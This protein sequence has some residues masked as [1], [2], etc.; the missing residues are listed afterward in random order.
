MRCLETLRERWV[1]RLLGL[2]R[3]MRKRTHWLPLDRLFL[4]LISGAGHNLARK[5]PSLGWISIRPPKSVTVSH[6][7]SHEVVVVGSVAG[8][9]GSWGVDLVA[10]AGGL[11]TKRLISARTRVG[12]WRCTTGGI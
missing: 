7:L 11:S 9:H 1:R 4:S 12:F 5:V 3:Y 2:L 6:G 8:S 10:L